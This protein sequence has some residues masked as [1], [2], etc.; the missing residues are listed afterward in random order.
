MQQEALINTYPC[1]I[2][3]PT[4]AQGILQLVLILTLVLYSLWMFSL[5]I[6]GIFLTSHI[7]WVGCQG[8]RLELRGYPCSLWK[9]FHTL[10]VQASIHP[11]ALVG[12]GN[13][14]PNRAGMSGLLSSLSS[15]V[16]GMC[17]HKYLQDFA[18]LS[19]RCR[20]GS[21]PSLEVSISEF[22]HHE[23]SLPQC[24]RQ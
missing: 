23:H 4:K 10:T 24:G 16:H 18:L 14:L 1:M 7:K 8:S 13:H 2:I 9:L 20:A 22:R 11:E 6:S 15:S 5:Q 17:Y 21:M 3:S 19:V 12:T